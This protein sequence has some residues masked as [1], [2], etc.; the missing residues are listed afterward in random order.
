MG[1]VVYNT[2]MI[3]ELDKVLDGHNI[4]SRKKFCKQNNI[5]FQALQSLNGSN[6]HMP[7]GSLAPFHHFYSKV[8]KK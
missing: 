7:I 4:H 3:V 1:T 5:Y 8:I 6:F 2:Y